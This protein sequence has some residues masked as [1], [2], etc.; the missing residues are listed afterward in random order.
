MKRRVLLAVFALAVVTA[1][2]QRKPKKVMVINPVVGRP[3]AVLDTPVSADVPRP[4]L[5]VGIV[6]DQMRWDYLFRYYSRYGNGGFKRLLNEGFSCDNTQIDY[7][8]T[9]TAPGHTC[10]YTGSVPAIHGIAGNDFIVQATGKSMY[11]AE[12]TTVQTV[13]STS[14][15]GKMSPRNM[16]VTTV[17]DELRLATNFRSK[18]IGIALKDRGGILPAGHTANAAYWFDDKTGNWISSTYYMKDLPQW[19]KDLNDQKLPETYLKQDWT[20]L[21]PIETYVQ[22]TA[23]SNGYEGKF[24]GM[25]APT[26]PVKTSGMY[27]NNLG[28]IRST[29]YGNTLTLD[30]A[31]AAINAEKLGQRDVTDFL[32]VSFSST[33]YVGHQFGPNAIETE[34]TYLRLD[35]DLATLFTYLDAKVGKGKYAVFITADHGA[36][37]NPNFLKD[38]GVPAGVWNEGQALKGL[39]AYLSSKYTIDGLVRSLTNYQVNLN[40]YAV[41]YAHLDVDKLKK[42][43]MD[44]LQ[45]DPAIA[46]VVDMQKPMT[47]DLPEVLRTRVINGYNAEHSGVIQ[48]MLKPGYFTGGAT[49]TT[50]GT[51]NPYDNHIPLVFMGWGIN[52]G[53]LDRETHMTDIAATVAA[54]LHIQTPNGCIGHPI[55][56][57]LK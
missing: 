3:A 21:Y 24:R 50:H 43:C 33:D 55:T 16:L 38:H 54:L 28:L 52:H 5:M 22:S 12:D 15:A 29:P 31:V 26:M 2:A 46:F 23:D 42:D 14:D 41:N 35:R 13:G 27:K 20:T 53:R 49:G 25:T 47:A 9:F 32:T 4:R 57:A 56:E 34:D 44:F 17:T 1:S 30:M 7:L 45:K 40:N 19:V 6:V 11:C 18:T 39:N 36:A 8:P 51:W 10:V 48:I 37:H